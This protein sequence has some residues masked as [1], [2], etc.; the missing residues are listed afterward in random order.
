MGNVGTIERVKPSNWVEVVVEGRKVMFTPKNGHNELIV[1]F[2]NPR[3]FNPPCTVLHI[4]R[5]ETVTLNAKPGESLYDV[6]EPDKIDRPVTTP[7]GSGPGNAK[8]YTPEPS[9][10]SG[11]II[12]T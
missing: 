8:S 7:P 3:L 5:F 4:S 10:P 9:N 1:K 6:F 12:V 11:P 2:H